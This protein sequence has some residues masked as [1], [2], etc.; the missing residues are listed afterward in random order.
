MG[1]LRGQRREK[2]W[3]G[4]K[5]AEREKDGLKYFVEEKEEESFVCHSE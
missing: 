2:V 3:G 1:M 5:D 4:R